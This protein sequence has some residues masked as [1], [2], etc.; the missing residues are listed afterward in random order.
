MF[1]KIMLALLALVAGFASPGMG[2]MD[3]RTYPII[4]IP[5]KIQAQKGQFEVS[6]KTLISTDVKEAEIDWVIQYL[7]QHL[8]SRMDVALPVSKSGK[9]SASA[10]Y[11]KLLPGAV[12]PESYRLTIDAKQILIEGGDPAGLF[13]GVQSLIQLLPDGDRL[14]LPS[15]SVEDHPAFPYRGMHLDVGRHFFPVA[16]VKQ[17]I[18]MLARYKM[19]RFHWHLTEDQ[20]WRIE[21]KRYPKLQEV[22]AFRKETLIGSYNNQPQQYDGK[23]YGGFYTQ[24]EIKEIV[25]YA[26]ERFV[27]IVP[28]IELPGHA[29]AAIAAYPELGC[30]G[31]PVE[32]ATK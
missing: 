15:L 20:G 17:Y 5:Q 23:R 29:Q 4:P 1:Y 18:D 10:I 14:V 28:E 3:A 6:A 12:K 32:V 2:Q 22:A 26:Q 31:Q 11:L 8:Q 7:N 21:I 25:R 19:N 24:E 30:A 27:T 13:Y 16:F 9:K